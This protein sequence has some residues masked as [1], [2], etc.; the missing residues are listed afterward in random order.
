MIYQSAFEKSLCGV[1]AEVTR[2]EY[3]GQFVAFWQ[4]SEPRYLGCYNFR[5]LSQSWIPWLVALVCVFAF[6]T[7]ARPESPLP[8]A[9]VF[10]GD[11]PNHN[12]ALARELA[13]AAGSAGFQIQ[14]IDTSALLN[15]QT[16]TKTN[17]PLLILAD[18]RALPA[19]AEH[20]VQ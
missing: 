5:T 9:A 19:N 8:T 12:P 13:A 6:A 16:L 1:A 20:A 18:A 2:L 4:R 11:F 3:A 14:F 10:N 15:A 7:S 17:F